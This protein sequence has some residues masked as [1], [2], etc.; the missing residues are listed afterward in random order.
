MFHNYLREYLKSDEFVMV[1]EHENIVAN[2]TNKQMAQSNN[3]C[4][5]SRSYIVKF[6][7]NVRRLSISSYPNPTSLTWPTPT[8]HC[9]S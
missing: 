2:D 8:D 9:S 7:I 5:S 3:I 1:Y 6:K 4:S